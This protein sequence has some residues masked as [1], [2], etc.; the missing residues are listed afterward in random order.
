M[1]A[2]AHRT[3][4]EHLAEVLAAVTPLESTTVLL[5]DAAGSTLAVPVVAPTDAPGFRSSAMDGF[6]VRAVDAA[7]ASPESPARLRVIADLP[8]GTELDP[9]LAQ[10]EAARIMTG[11]PVPTAADA[12]VPLEHTSAGLFG[13]PDVDV[14]RAPTVGQ[15]VRPSGEDVRTGVEV[16]RAG[17]ALGALQLGSIAAAGVTEVVVARRPRV[18]VVSTGSELAAPGAPLRRGMIPESN[19]PMLSRLTEDAGADLV[20]VAT[21]PDVNAEFE[22]ALEDA[23]AAGADVVIT[24][25]GVGTGAYE[26]VRNTLEPIGGMEFVTVAMRPGR[27]QGFGRLASGAL[28]FGL[29]GTP[30]GAAVSFEV[31]VRPALL[32]MQGRRELHRPRLLLRAAEGW[33]SRAGHRHLVPATIDRTDPRGW[34]VRPA[35][36][37]HSTTALAYTDAFV[38][39]PEDVE[40]VRVG[41]L[42]EAML[43]GMS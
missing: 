12:V 33:R 20:L 7:S 30:I 35:G 19:A 17:V 29:P 34:T 4:D 40:E 3:V 28:A 1:P 25:G 13:G 22:R 38:V 26:V 36:G 15:H 32:A 42:V 27:P 10:G 16:V 37:A 8:A 18:A 5:R 9:P 2:R 39:V 11:A 24:S 31:F 14:V 6:A 43:V 41:D 23:T 21:V